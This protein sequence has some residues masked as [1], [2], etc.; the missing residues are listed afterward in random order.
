MLLLINNTLYY[1]LYIEAE[2]LEMRKEKPYSVI[3]IPII[4]CYDVLL[5]IAHVLK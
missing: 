2:E 4:A 3:S 5:S 1:I